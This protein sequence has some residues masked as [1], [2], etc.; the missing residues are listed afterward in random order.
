MFARYGYGCAGQLELLAYSVVRGILMLITAIYTP[1]SE[2]KKHVLQNVLCI[3]R[4]TFEGL[5][6]CR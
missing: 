1:L 2:V 5:L 6:P 4:R 3:M